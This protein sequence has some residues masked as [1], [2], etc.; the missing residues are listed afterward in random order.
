MNCLLSSIV[1]M[2]YGRLFQSLMIFGNENI[3]VAVFICLDYLVT[4]LDDCAV[5]DAE[6]AEEGH[7]LVGQEA[8]ILLSEVLRVY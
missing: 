3:L 2:L 4:F 1:V 6:A 5:T 8:S 7:P